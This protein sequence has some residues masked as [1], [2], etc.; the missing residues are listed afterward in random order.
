MKWYITLI[1]GII[2]ASFTWILNQDHYDVRYTL[3]EK[4]PLSFGN[5]Q[6]DAVQQLEVKN[7]SNKEVEKI[8]IKLPPRVSQ[9][10]L[11][12]N[13]QADIEQSFQK[14]TNFELL[15]PA[16]PPQGSFR[17][18]IKTT[19][20]GI[21]KHEIQINHS[22]GPVHE[23][24]TDNSSLASIIF[25]LIFIVLFVWQLLI[26]L[27]DFSA[28]RWEYLAEYHSEKV[29]NSPK[30]ILVPS[31]NWKK[32]RGKA[33]SRFGEIELF[34]SI[35]PSYI[36]GLPIYKYLNNEKPDNLSEEEW[37]Q[38]IQIT[39]EK[40]ISALD[41]RVATSWADINEIIA[42]LK[43]KRPEKSPSDKWEKWQENLEKI[44][45]NRQ[46]QDDFTTYDAFSHFAAKVQKLKKPDEIR[47]SLWDKY[48]N[49]IAETWFSTLLTELE[50]QRS[51]S[52]IEFLN[53]QNLQ[54]LK[55]DHEERLRRR[56]YKLQ[57]LSLP[58]LTDEESAKKFLDQQKPDWLDEQDYTR[59]KL[60]AERTL[61]VADGDR[62]NAIEQARLFKESEELAKTKEKI[63]KQLSILHE[64]FVDSKSIDR[65]ESYDNPFAPGNFEILKQISILLGKVD[66]P[67]S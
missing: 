48:Q 5:G 40:L 44:Y 31:K 12:K 56:A 14:P 4:I 63:L 33:I 26:A 61:R 43:V 20:D 3:S 41:K 65:I 38:F 67:S 17:L 49:K 30:P 24:L 10:E 42:T 55:K 13:S 57:I 25:G 2:V 6:Q 45:I 46:I 47:D 51:Y 34:R 54:I 64:I 58:D 21:S 52:P 1:I 23:A 50:S 39:T 9:F 60:I 18:V 62:I 27:R 15:Y 11:F 22:R 8:Q 37:Q 35:L 29:L 66:T 28:S 53:Q 59:R 16:L 32:L 19:G 7:L 36:E